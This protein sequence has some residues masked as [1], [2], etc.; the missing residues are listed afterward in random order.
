[1][2]IVEEKS[3]LDCGCIESNLQKE[4]ILIAGNLLII[5]YERVFVNMMT[6]NMFIMKVP[7]LNWQINCNN[8]NTL[9]L[10]FRVVCKQND[11]VK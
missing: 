8:I 9:S 5:M 7:G 3:R 2:L 10:V 6:K 11:L 1:M 4:A